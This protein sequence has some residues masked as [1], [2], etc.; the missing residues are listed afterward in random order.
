[1]RFSQLFSPTLKE[2]PAEA[3]TPSHQLMLRAGIIRKLASGIYTYLP[4]GVKSLEKISS[5]I[6]EELNRIG[7]QEVLMPVLHPKELWQQ[8]GRWEKVEVLFRLKDRADRDFLLGP[9]HEEV[10]TSLVAHEVKSYRQLPLLLYQIQTKFRDEPRPR[11]GVIRSREFI[12]MDLY[13]FHK[14]KEDL[15]KTYWKVYEAYQRIYKRSGFTIRVVEGETGDIGG[16]VSHQF[17]L[18]SKS[19]EDTLLICP[20]CS[21]GA[22]VWSVPCREPNLKTENSTLYPKIEKIHTPNCKTILALVQYF[23]NLTKNENLTE[24]NFIKTLVY[25][26]DGK[27]IAVCI[28]GDREINEMKLKRFLGVKKLEMAKGE[29]LGSWALILGFIG[30][31][32]LTMLPHGVKFSGAR[33]EINETPRIIADY[34]VQGMQDAVCGANEQDYHFQHVGYGRDFT[35]K[36]FADLRMAEPGD[37]C[38]KCGS[39][40]KLENGIE[41][42]QIF[43]LGTIYSK[44]LGCVYLDEDGREVPMIMGC[45][46]IGVSRMLASL[47]EQ[48][49][50][51]DGISWPISTAPYDAV[52]V[53]VNNQDETQMK[54]SE[55]IYEE[56]LGSNLDV[57][58][59][60]REVRAGVKF[61]DADLL[62]FPFRITVGRGA[63]EGKVEI[64]I[65]EN[66]KTLEIT[67]DKILEELKKIREAA[68][69]ELKPDPKEPVSI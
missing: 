63:Q 48:H 9:T 57:I 46:G 56:C 64:K 26:A 52:I 44:P 51:K 54:L 41:L 39:T 31:V 42:G 35:I 27:L 30:P 33:E 12:M 45:Y 49:H 28:R 37:P 2:V 61:K 69:Q 50:D 18:I 65:R 1:M 11:G 67:A 47:I 7:A 5:I 68:L 40:L 32:G 4:L 17:E 53:P 59:D 34:E 29:T 23:K 24:A 22:D 36:E 20:N 14:T 66:G 25:E 43:N 6:R 16:D 38:P 3:E 19:G 8:T 60:D 55:K 62:G 15:E 13:S 21:Y 10:I 58:L